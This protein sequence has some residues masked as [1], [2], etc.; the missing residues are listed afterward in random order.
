MKK[1]LLLLFFLLFFSFE[2]FALPRFALQQG[3]RCIDCHVNPSGGLIRTESG[4][5]FGKNVVGMISPRDKIVSTS[6]KIGENIYLGVD[7]RTQYIYAEELR[8]TDFQKMAAAFYASIK[9]NEKIDAVAKYDFITQVFEGYGVARILPN[10]SYIKV[11]TFTPN[12]GIK[13]DDHTA[14]TRGGDFGL[15]APGSFSPGLYLTPYYTETGIEL[16]AYIGEIAYLSASVGRSSLHGQMFSKDPIYTG[17]AEFTPHFGR[18]GTSFGASYTAFN[19]PGNFGQKSDIYG[20]FAGIG[21]D[22]ISLQGEYDM[23]DN[24]DADITNELKSS[25]LML[26]ATYRFMVGVEGIVRYDMIDPDKDSDMDSMSRLILGV[27]YFPYSFI[28]LRPQYRFNFEDPGV[29]NN[30]FVLQFHIWY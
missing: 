27:E 28:E 10:N 9:I 20:F 18:L 30:V 21:Y 8:K 15:A 4:W 19:T 29:V 12:F 3:D 6:P 26:K 22:K 14:Y 16:G 23:G 2:F 7:F 17:R 25:Y 5:Y 13:L 24:Y 11:G 1:L